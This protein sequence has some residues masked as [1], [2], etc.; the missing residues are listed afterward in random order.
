MK[1]SV[2]EIADMAEKLY[3]ALHINIKT[4][5]EDILPIMLSTNNAD[6]QA[7]RLVYSEGFKQNLIKDFKKNLSGTFMKLSV[8]MFYTQIEH[9]SKQLHRSMK[10][11]FQDDECFFEILASR[12]KLMFEDIKQKFKEMYSKDLMKEIENYVPND[13]KR[14]MSCLLTTERDESDYPNI[15]DCLSDAKLLIDTPFKKWTSNLDLFNKVFVITSPTAL[16]Y[17]ARAYYEKT[18]KTLLQAIDKEFSG[19]TK[20][21][22]KA[23]LYSNINTAEWYADKFNKAI[24]G[25]GTDTNLL[26]RIIVTR[27]D[28]DLSLIKDFYNYLYKKTLQD[29]VRDDTSGTYQKLLLGILD[30]QVVE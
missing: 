16:V 12:P 20:A 25:L 29:A 17:I 21:L 5:E 13:L 8:D 27:I 22:L 23:I 9:D 2:D 19:K 18:G 4:A 14:I 26:D 15:D 28:M 30:S 10:F 1:A 24:K 6:R 3:S 7:I 11:V